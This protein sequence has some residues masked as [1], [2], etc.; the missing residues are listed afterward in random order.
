MQL[1]LSSVGLIQA[2]AGTLGSATHGSINSSV[3]T[4]DNMLSYLPILFPILFGLLLS[5]ILLIVAKLLG[6]YRPSKAKS[7]PYESGFGASS[8]PKIKFNIP[9]YRIALLFLVF[10][11]EAA[12]FYP[13]AVLFRDLSC[14]GERVAGVCQGSVSFFGI[15]VM[16]VFLSILLLGLVYVW[17]TGALEWDS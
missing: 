10:D 8:T 17:R 3:T 11:I 12:F 6:P 13:W 7:L 1:G 14:T 16:V 2:R 4:H 15:G 9:F 5:V